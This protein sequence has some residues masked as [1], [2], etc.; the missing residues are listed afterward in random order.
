MIT[1]SAYIS[2]HTAIEY[3]GMPDQ[4]FYDV[5]VSSKTRFHDFEF[6]VE[7]VQYSGGNRVSQM[8]HLL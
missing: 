8:Y 6:G 3:H 7:E 2:H 5:Y 4:V 1:E